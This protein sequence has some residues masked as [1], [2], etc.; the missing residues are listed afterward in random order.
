MPPKGESALFYFRGDFAP[1]NDRGGVTGE[2]M[3][4]S[5]ARGFTLQYL[6][7]HHKVG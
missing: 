5:L 6:E 1:F 7:I 3:G 2:A 4:K